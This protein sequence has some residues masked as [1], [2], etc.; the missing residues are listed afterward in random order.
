MTTLQPPTLTDRSKPWGVIKFIHKDGIEH[1]FYSAVNRL[2]GDRLSAFDSD[3]PTYDNT[4]AWAKS[5]FQDIHKK[6]T[7]IEAAGKMAL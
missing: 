7:V 4:G 3:A 1:K 6:A 5:V 2:T